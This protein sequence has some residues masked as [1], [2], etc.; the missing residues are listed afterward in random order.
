MIMNKKLLLLIV[1]IIMSVISA[2]YL[3]KLKSTDSNEADNTILEL[4]KQHAQF[5]ANSPFKKTLNLSKKERKELGI[6]PNKYFERE[7]ELTMDPATG[8][9]Q[10]ERLF[11]LQESLKRKGLANKV[12]GSE[13]DNSWEERGPNNVGGRTRAIMFDPN[14]ATNKRVFAGGVSGGLWVNND[15]TD[16]NSAWSLVEMPQNLAISV[17]TY[18]P[19]DKNIF[20][21]GTGE[22]Y[23]GGDVNGNGLWQSIDRGVNWSKI[24]GG[25]TGETTFQI[26]IKL[27]VNSPSS[28]IKDYQF[29]TGSFGPTAEYSITGDLV[30]A[31]DSSALPTEA[32]NALTNNAA[33]SGNIAVVERGSCTFVSKV[34]NAQDAGAIAVLVINNVDGPP[35][36]MAGDDVTIT[37]PSLMISKEDG[38]L[39]MN[40]LVSGVNIS[41]QGN[42]IPY[43]Q[44]FITPGIQ[45]I[46][47]VKVRDIGG[48]NSEVYVAVGESFYSNSTPSSFLGTEEYGLYK[49]VNKGGS[50]AKLA[51]P[52]TTRGNEIVPNDLEIGSDNTIWL[53]TTAGIFYGDGGG[54]I[55]SS[56]DG[57]NFEVKHTI[58]EGDRTQIAVSKLN[59]GVVY[60]LA[61][62]G[63]AGATPV[64][65]AYTND[66][67]TTVNEITPPADVD[68]GI[69]NDDFTRGQAFYDLMIEVDPTNDAI[70]YVGGIDLFRSADGGVN[71]DQI[72]KWS[73]N[74]N[75]G[76]LSVPSVHADQHAFVFNPSDANQGVFGNDGGI[77]FGTSLS[78]ATTTS[79]AISARN[80]NYNTLQFY[81]GAIGSDVSSEKLLAGAQDNGSQLI[82]GATTGVNGSI[83]VSGGDGAYTFIDKDNGYMISSYV[84][85]NYYYLNYETGDYV[86]EIAA[87]DNDGDFIN[88]AALDSDHN[89]LYASGSSKIIRYKLGWTTATTT[90]LE[91]GLLTTSPTAFKTSTFT[92]STL[93]VG[94]ENGKLLKLLNAN[95][96]TPTW[97]DITGDLFYGSI[98]CIELGATENDI[99]VTFHNYGVVNVYF[100]QDGGTT[101]Q[102]KEGNLP[103][104]PVKAI[105]MNPLNNNQVI[106]GTDLGVWRTSNFNDASPT[107][108]QSQNGMKDVQVTSFDLRTSD[109]TVLASTYG[110]GMFTGVFSIEDE[111]NIDSDG[112]GIL[113]SLD[114]CPDTANADQLDT[115][116]DGV[117]DVCDI[118]ADFDD[119][120][121]TDNDGIPDGC[122]LTPTGDDDNDGIDNAVDNCIATPNPNQL[123]T[124][125]DGV[126]DVCDTTPTGDN[127]GDGIDNAIDNCIDIANTDQADTD[128]DGIGDVC[129]DDSDNDGIL[130]NV[131][132]CPNTANPNQL[133]TDSD[134]IGDLCDATPTGD[135]DNDG[136]D[137]AIDNCPN[138]VNP[139][140]LD[141]DS[142]GIG[143]VCD[144]TPTGDDDGDGID[145]A[146]DNCPNMV[147]PNQTDTD[148]DGIGDVCDATPNGDNDNDGIDNTIDN[149]PNTANPNQLDTDSDGIGDLC[150]ATPNGDDDND[151][152]D[153]AIDNC[154]NTVNPNQLDTDSDGIGDVC[155]A[156]PNGDDDNDGIDN[157][158]DNCPTE[159]NPNQLDTDNDGIGDVCDATPNGDDDN[160]GVDNAVD[161]CSGTPLGAL[162]D[163][164]GCFTLPS[165]NFSIEVTSETCPNKD[166]GQISI[167]ATAAYTYTTTINGVDYTFDTN[168]GVLATGLPPTNYTVCISVTGE[169]YEQCFDV[170]VISGT[171]VSGKSSV[172]SGKA[173]IVIEQG[174]APFDIYVNGQE[175][176]KTSS[177]QFNVDVK[178]GD[179]IEVKTAKSCEGVYSK[180]VELLEEIIAYPNPSN[181]A[182]EISLPVTQKEVVIELYS[183]ESQLISTKTYPIS[184]GKVR[185][186][187]ENQ[188]V[189]IYIVKV[190]LKSPV[191]LKIIKQ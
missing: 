89:V 93:F 75:L 79:T 126:G 169:T 191:T 125:A 19:N 70:L 31:D 156:T 66:S 52:L 4:R 112:D 109:N 122:D 87:N 180:T 92:T 139:N 130:N 27:T 58:A 39:I 107:W 97:V 76:G 91:N 146:I 94:T 85:N 41:L 176:F 179:L 55:L 10:P 53:S 189:G 38:A 136:I 11:S 173:S 36:G 149:C 159:A 61:E 8:K 163:A 82:N 63:S 133:D 128:N 182:F 73:N 137:N 172:A 67:F 158:V 184:Y 51:L 46:N 98:S 6:P 154:P 116:V 157:A 148:N 110:R 62:L 65:M 186:N 80:T 103:D 135:D 45:H 3:I 35:I 56:S 123:D 88:P 17:I 28:L 174:T 132:N 177:T 142:D 168:N 145:N 74:N 54:T 111:L 119:T 22:S 117:G 115:D 77:Y 49:S 43:T 29:T 147:N 84:Y 78:D 2:N 166:N 171:T 21:V 37:I 9:P 124:D 129:D 113:D 131:D 160:D 48:G 34:K 127:D 151:G 47:D 15:I 118:C 18:D 20:Y 155:D 190:Q 5:L 114:N 185:L 81:K 59:A 13:M 100:S 161:L 121:D 102:N 44:S 188:P 104:L 40:E 23:V 95:S 30:L 12:P 68:T 14:D 164:T 7:W 57:V 86:Y 106:I 138:T 1:G 144:L 69:P 50:W 42:G 99:M 183:I 83:K 141:T 150:D 60:V 167:S 108:S 33:I 64:Y 143:D 105:L 26:N 175:S 71:W 165:N 170:E 181:G 153:N 134:G 96:T 16:E 72:S 162:V 25:I 101:W 178:H 152:I 90:N 32:C 187:I 120:I 24:F 140:Q